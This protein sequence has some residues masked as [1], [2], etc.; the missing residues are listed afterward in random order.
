MHYG[1]SN[2]KS[3]LFIDDHQ[4][5]TTESERDLG[6]IF[7][8]NL[9]WKN[10]VIGKANQMLNMITKCFVHLDTKLLRSLY[11]TF[12]RPLIEFA[13]PVWSP[14]QKSD[15]EMLER[16]QHRATRLIPSLRKIIYEKRLK[17]L[18]LTTLTERRQRGDMIQLYKIFNGKDTI[19]IMNLAIKIIKQEDIALNTIKKSQSKRIVKILFSTDQ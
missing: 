10:Q 17:A 15:I 8:N 13:V 11:V 2:K 5:I 16:V 19:E 6:V 12:I 4:L 1:F 9:K 7:L 18:D 14:Y 3:P